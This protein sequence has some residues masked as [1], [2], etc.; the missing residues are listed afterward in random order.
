MLMMMAVRG[1]GCAVLMMAGEGEGCA[2][3]KMAGAGE[4]RGADD[5]R[6]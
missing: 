5:A 2:V 3:L 6:G 4:L 1:E